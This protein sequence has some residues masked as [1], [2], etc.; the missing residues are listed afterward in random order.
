M[1]VLTIKLEDISGNP[2]NAIEVVIGSIVT[3]K[4][5]GDSSIVVGN[6]VKTSTDATGTATIEVKATPENI[7]GNNYSINWGDETF[8]FRMPDMDVE[9]FDIL[10]VTEPPVPSRAVVGQGGLDIDDVIQLINAAGHADTKYV[11]DRVAGNFVTDVNYNNGTVTVT[12]TDGSI[13]TFDVPTADAGTITYNSIYFMRDDRS[14]VEGNYGE[15]SYV[16]RAT[17][18]QAWIDAGISGFTTSLTHFYVAVRDVNVPLLRRRRKTALGGWTDAS[19][20]ETV[21]LPGNSFDLHNDGDI[22]DIRVDDTYL[23]MQ[24][25]RK[26]FR[27]AENNISWKE[28]FPNLE[29]I[30]SDVGL[31]ETFFVQATAAEGVIYAIT[32]YANGR[33][34]LHRKDINDAVLQGPSHADWS[35]TAWTYIKDLGTV[36]N[37]VWDIS[38]NR[39]YFLVVRSTGTPYTYAITVNDTVTGRVIGRE[40]IDTPQ[41]T[42]TVLTFSINRALGDKKELGG[43]TESDIRNLAISMG[44]LTSAQAT[45]LINSLG[46]LEE[47][48][49]RNIVDAAT[50]YSSEITN[51]LL[52]S[53]F[54]ATTGL[55]CSFT[56]ATTLDIAVITNSDSKLIDSLLE[57][58]HVQ[59][60]DVIFVL[61]ANAASH[62]SGTTGE[63]RLTGS[64]LQ[65]TTDLLAGTR[66]RLR[67][68]QA[69]PGV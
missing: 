17:F 29:Q 35:T 48:Q 25:N 24:R 61:S 1:P 47:A 62:P 45:T 40:L 12:K 55:R 43:L 52:R 23:Y 68:S 32:E 53:D 37:V 67:F 9:L 4:D 18:P 60:G 33:K 10:D 58:S 27:T 28:L 30:V 11:D 50:T 44:F 41:R 59:I 15:T 56:N 57:D 31:S 54:A 65:D 51:V 42:N 6:E 34:L 38:N 16:W 2:F 64:T 22:D 26:I 46:Y 19:N 49:V 8:Y 63:F 21:T 36:G 3:L 13:S 5:E 66:Y 20:W 69:R 7:P 39:I 14:I